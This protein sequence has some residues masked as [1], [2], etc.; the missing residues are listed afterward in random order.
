MVGIGRSRYLVGAICTKVEFEASDVFGW[1]LQV[2]SLRMKQVVLSLDWHSTGT[3]RD[4]LI[5]ATLCRDAVLQ[6]LD[7]RRMPC[8][9][10]DGRAVLARRYLIIRR[11]PVDRRRAVLSPLDGTYLRLRIPL[12]PVLFSATPHFRFASSREFSTLRL[13]TH[14]SLARLQPHTQLFKAA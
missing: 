12:A 14:D 2:E 10:A 4:L 11:M 8:K 13:L 7:R 5:P 9:C 6:V 3:E 1:R